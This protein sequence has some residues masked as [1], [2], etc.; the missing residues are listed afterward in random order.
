[1]FT[2][3]ITLNSTQSLRMKEIEDKVEVVPILSQTVKK[4]DEQVKNLED[5]NTELKEALPKKKNEET[6]EELKTQ[7]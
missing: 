3:V 2:A 7:N 4:L 6:I 1:M 5:Y